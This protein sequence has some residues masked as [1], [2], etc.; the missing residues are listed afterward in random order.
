LIDD[1]NL[2]RQ[3]IQRQSLQHQLFLPLIYLEN[4]PQLPELPG[5]KST[6]T[7]ASLEEDWISNLA[8][9]DL[10][11]QERARAFFSISVSPWHTQSW[12][13]E[14]MDATFVYQRCGEEID[15]C[16]FELNNAVSWIESEIQKMQVKSAEPRSEETRNSDLARA[17]ALRIKQ[18][19]AI[20]Y[21]I[22]RT[23][24]KNLTNAVKTSSENHRHLHLDSEITSLLS[25][26]QEL[27]EKYSN[28]NVVGPCEDE[29]EQMAEDIVEEGMGVEEDEDDEEW[30]DDSEE[31][32]DV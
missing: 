14:A 6:S 31:E 16:H 19:Q 24:T 17:Q 23:W 3:S 26:A 27:C 4:I 9:L 7:V 30:E 15:R 5:I 21:W 1:L 32:D 20:F 10:Q 8:T 29:V 25:R 18:V 11:T 13:R 28:G 22:L 2:R 12:L